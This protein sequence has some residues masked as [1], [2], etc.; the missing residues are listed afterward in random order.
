MCM[1]FGS[2]EMDERGKERGAATILERQGHWWLTYDN[3]VPLFPS[4]KE[5]MGS[6]GSS[7][8]T[9]REVIPGRQERIVNAK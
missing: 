2:K 9:G 7:E 4:T 6:R 3:V 1:P 8:E 5:N